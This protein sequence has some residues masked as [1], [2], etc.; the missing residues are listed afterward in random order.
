MSDPGTDY[1]FAQN[2]VAEHM[3]AIASHIGLML[4]DMDDVTEDRRVRDY[5]ML[6]KAATMVCCML[7]QSPNGTDIMRTLAHT[8][9][10]AARFMDDG[11]EVK[12][13]VPLALSA[14]R[15]HLLARQRGRG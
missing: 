3:H 13:A 4:S 11:K 14:T 9:T 8:V 6:E 15:D 10:H 12:F 5:M 1:V 7:S 2:A